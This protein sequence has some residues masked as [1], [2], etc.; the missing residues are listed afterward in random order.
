[1]GLVWEETFAEA[2]GANGSL[3]DLRS[4]FERSIRPLARAQRRLVCRAASSQSC[5]IHRAE[6]GR[7]SDEVL[8][9]PSAAAANVAEEPIR[10]VTGRA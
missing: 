2:I 5:R 10:N 9:C 3:S 1:M 7:M 8:T 4:S 6:N